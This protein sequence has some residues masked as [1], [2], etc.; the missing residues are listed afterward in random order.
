MI[1]DFITLH[2]DYWVLLWLFYQAKK[3]AND[4]LVKHGLRKGIPSSDQL[5]TKRVDPA[6]LEVSFLFLYWLVYLSSFFL[7]EE[8]ESCHQ[9]S[10]RKKESLWGGGDLLQLLLR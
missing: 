3:D 4:A 5:S 9:R 6:K 2:V 7:Y 1:L 8:N 10:R